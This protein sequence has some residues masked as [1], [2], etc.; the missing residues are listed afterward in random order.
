M[1]LT[2]HVGVFANRLGKVHKKSHRL[3]W[4]LIR[5]FSCTQSGNRTRTPVEGTGF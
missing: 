5:F 4:L 2:Y 3:G 1:L